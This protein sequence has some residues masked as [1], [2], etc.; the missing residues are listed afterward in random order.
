MLILSA[1]KVGIVGRGRREVGGDALEN[2]EGRL[3]GGKGM[4]RGEVVRP[5]CLRGFDGVE[6]HATFG[7]QGQEHGAFV[8]GIGQKLDKFEAH[9]L[10]GGLLDT[11]AGE[12]HVAGNPGDGGGTVLDDAEDLPAGRGQARR[13]G[14]GV[15]CVQEEA[16]EAKDFDDELGKGI[17][18]LVEFVH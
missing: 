13:R 6:R 5:D 1:G 3:E 14:E 18:A 15:A 8:V 11:L 17:A 7:G 9:K 4:M 16:I 12:S 2:S 10:I